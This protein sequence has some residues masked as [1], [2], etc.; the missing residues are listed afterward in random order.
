MVP[1]SVSD[2]AVIVTVPVAV[3]SPGTELP[4][5]V[6]VCFRTARAWGSR[7]GVA[8]DC[9]EIRREDEARV[10]TEERTSRATRMRR[11]CHWP[12]DRLGHDGAP[13]ATL[14]CLNADGGAWQE[15]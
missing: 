3:E 6:T 9:C 4:M 7:C 14:I 15:G 13:W 11:P 1:T 5:A 2:P 10:R 8:V 12:R